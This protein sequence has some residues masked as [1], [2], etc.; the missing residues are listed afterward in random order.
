MKVIERIRNAVRNDKYRVTAH[1]NE[2]MSEDNMEIHDIENIILS[3][4]II[5]KYTH[6]PRGTRYKILGKTT[7]NRE[8]FV[9]CRF[10]ESG[11]LLVI[12]TFV[13]GK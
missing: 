5:K 10:L 1:A 3:G 4:K 11:I 12:T 13:R 8:A 2:E 7:D 9:I 6:D